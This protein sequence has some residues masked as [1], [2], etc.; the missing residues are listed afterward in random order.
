MTASIRLLS[1]FRGSSAQGYR[2]WRKGLLEEAEDRLRAALRA[3]P[4][5]AGARL[6]LARVLSERGKPEEALAALE[7]PL[8]PPSAEGVRAVFRGI[9]LYDHRDPGSPREAFEAAGPSNVLARAFAS[10]LDLSEK[11]ERLEAPEGEDGCSP[12]ADSPSP[13]TRPRAVATMPLAARYVADVSA[14]AL[15]ALEAAFLRLRPRGWLEFH[16]AYLAESPD[17][18]PREGEARTEAPGGTSVPSAAPGETAA[19]GEAAAG[20]QAAAKARPAA[21][22]RTPAEGK[23]AAREI[24][25]ERLEAALRRRDYEAF[26]ET[27]KAKDV[28]RS[29]LTPEIAALRAFALGALGRAERAIEILEPVTEEEPSEPLA[30]FVLGLSHLRSGRR[31][32]ASWCFSRAARLADISV[33]DLIQE[34]SRA[35]GIAWDYA[36]P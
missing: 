23:V 18:R 27:A 19:P 9:I 11:L 7:G 29:W 22:G 2:A 10:L 28:P 25:R 21:Q 31:R 16:H 24:W 33:D 3:R 6:Y 20:S 36:D 8:E 32:E 5:A 30:H 35:L 1:G 34:I 15:A 14:R 17:E 12:G 13:A 4:H 26:E